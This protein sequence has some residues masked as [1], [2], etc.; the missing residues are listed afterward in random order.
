MVLPRIIVC[1][2]EWCSSLIEPCVVLLYNVFLASKYCIIYK[3]K[4]CSCATTKS[5]TRWI[6]S[7]WRVMNT[8]TVIVVTQIPSYSLYILHWQN[9]SSLYSLYSM[10]QVLIWDCFII[11]M[12]EKV[13]GQ[14]LPASFCIQPKLPKVQHHFKW[15]VQQRRGSIDTGYGLFCTRRSVG[16]PIKASAFSVT[17]FD[18]NVH[19][20][21]AE[22]S[23]VTHTNISIYTLFVQRASA[24][25]S[26]N[27]TTHAQQFSWQFY[28]LCFLTSVPC[29]L[30]LCFRAVVTK[31]FRSSPKR[32]MFAHYPNYE[33][34]R[35]FLIYGI[36]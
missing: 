12:W 27:Q 1:F 13:H 9:L 19:R 33:N 15:K 25:H 10:L 32:E 26:K 20:V 28:C 3:I 16:S 5:V 18:W 31:P 23:R 21:N 14:V 29:D 24:W 34:S 7:H 30:T 8:I 17:S 35:S 6:L 36:Y 11:K 22:D 2:Q 4:Y